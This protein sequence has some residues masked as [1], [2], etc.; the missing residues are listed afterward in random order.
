MLTVCIEVISTD[1]YEIQNFLPKIILAAINC[2]LPKGPCKLQI[3]TA[4]IF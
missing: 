1:I 3:N 2:D 4:F